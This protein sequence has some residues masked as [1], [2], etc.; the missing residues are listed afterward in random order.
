MATTQIVTETGETTNITK[1]EAPWEFIDTN[2]VTQIYDTTFGV[3][4][5]DK[6]NIKYDD[7]FDE[8]FTGYGSEETPFN[9]AVVSQRIQI[10]EGGSNTKIHKNFGTLNTQESS[11]ILAKAETEYPDAVEEAHGFFQHL[12]YKN[13]FFNFREMFIVTHEFNAGGR[14][15]SPNDLNEMKSGETF[16]LGAAATYYD[17]YL[18]R[19]GLSVETKEIM[20]KFN[21]QIGN[22]GFACHE[23]HD[24]KRKFFIV[25]TRN[26]LYENFVSRSKAERLAM[27][28]E[29]DFFD[30]TGDLLSNVLDIQFDFT[31][32][33]DETSYN[34][35]LSFNP[36]YNFGILKP[37]YPV[38]EEE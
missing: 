21:I 30:Q 31:D 26:E 36:A 7:L 5:T 38:S 14:W 34:T 11:P 13:I 9:I 3:L 25:S 28:N 20:Q 24:A 6:F 2:E 27:L 23:E 4:V 12:I 10:Y 16:G 18:I 8:D 1:E 19:L 37:E 29:E 22:T 17:Y 35:E 33:P 15:L 32:Q